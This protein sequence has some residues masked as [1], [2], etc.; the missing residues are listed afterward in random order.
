MFKKNYVPLILMLVVMVI[1]GLL[2]ALTFL[3]KNYLI[4]FAVMIII[5]VAVSF[6][7]YPNLQKA[8]DKT[9][10]EG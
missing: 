10:N 4:V 5:I 1:A 2:C 3:V 6:I 8:A 9:Y 7:I